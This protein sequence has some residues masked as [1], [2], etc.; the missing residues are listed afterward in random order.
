MSNSKA[1]I[2]IVDDIAAHLK[3][4]ELMLKGGGYRVQAVTNGDAALSMV[5]ATP[6]DLI[7]LDIHMP[8]MNGYEVCEQLKSDPHI[9]HIPVIFI[10]ALGEGLDRGR[11]YDVGAVDFISKPFRMDEVLEKVENHLH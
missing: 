2:L 8:I 11:A 3:I 9:Q 4:L 6:P 7:L 10:T 1:N 5:H